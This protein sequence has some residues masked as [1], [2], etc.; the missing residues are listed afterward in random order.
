MSRVSKRK[1]VESVSTITYPRSRMPLT[2]L[3]SVS[4]FRPPSPT[5][6]ITYPPA[7][8][9]P[10]QTSLLSRASDVGS[11]CTAV[12]LPKN[13]TAVQTR[14]YSAAHGISGRR[15]FSSVS[16]VRE[17]LGWLDSQSLCNVQLC[18]HHTSHSRTNFSHWVWSRWPAIS[19]QVVSYQTV[20]EAHG[21]IIYSS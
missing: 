14:F 13:V 1:T 17:S 4:R 6:A 15:M 2:Y 8:L 9:P 3:G 5:S 7:H 16:N 18:T 10:S 21:R 20:W 11:Q 12:V 19:L